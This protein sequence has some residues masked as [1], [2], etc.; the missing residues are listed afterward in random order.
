MSS[1]DDGD[2]NLVMDFSTRDLDDLSLFA[3]EEGYPQD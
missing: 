3:Y 1:F 2:T